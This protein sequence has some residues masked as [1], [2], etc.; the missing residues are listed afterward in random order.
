MGFTLAQAQVTVVGLG[1]MGGSLAAALSTTG[2]CRRVVGVARRPSTLTMARS[3]RFI[4]WG[5][6]EL[7]A[8]VRQADIVILATPV[9]DILAK[10]KEIGPLLKPGCLLMD[11]GSTKLAICQAMEELPPHVQPI[12]GHPMCG[13]ETSG[14][15]MAEPDLYRDKV[16]VLTPLARTSAGA[17]ALAKALV[18]AIGARPLLLDPARHD[19]AVAAIS[20]LPY[21]LAASL[22]NAAAEFAQKDEL[23][24]KL[25]ASGF[26]D[27]S[28][29][30]AGSIPMMM[31]ILATNREPILTAL[32]QAQRELDFLAQCLEKNDFEKLRGRLEEARQHRLEV[33]P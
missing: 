7:A 23:V 17:I 26:R 29:V 2:A 9:Q 16:F 22:V 10:I 6:T 18:Q 19:R 27:T 3:L 31:D 32:R 20:H 24:W 13:K 4:H 28:R 33:F 15:T 5:T 21:L 1:L 14:L 25:A 8:G 11:V 30:A 12:G